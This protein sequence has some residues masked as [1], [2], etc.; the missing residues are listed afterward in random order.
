MDIV[1]TNVV[2]SLRVEA[3][4]NLRQLTSRLA[5]AVYNPSKFSAL[6]FKHRK[7]KGSC[8]LFANGKMICNGCRSVEQ[9]KTASRQ[10]ARYFQKRTP[11]TPLKIGKPSIVTISALADVKMPLNL[12]TLVSECSV[13]WEPERFNAAVISRANMHFSIFSSGKIIITGAKS[14]ASLYENAAPVLMEFMLV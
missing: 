1:I 10:F 2:L 14:V 4:F 12:R 3:H 7:I 11:S 13:R 5:N 6:I 9:A 8:L